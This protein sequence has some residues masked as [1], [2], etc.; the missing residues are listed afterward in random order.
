MPLPRLT[1]SPRVSRVVRPHSVLRVVLKLW[2]FDPDPHPKNDTFQKQ[3]TF[4]KRS[5]KHPHF[6][7]NQMEHDGS[8]GNLWQFMAHPPSAAK[9]SG[10]WSFCDG[11]EAVGHVSW[12]KSSAPE[13]TKVPRELVGSGKHG[14]FVGLF[15]KHES[16]GFR[17]NLY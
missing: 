13:V 11:P 3:D 9:S 17:H 7:N 6:R 14:K 1:W 2:P 12:N 5:T 8:Y 10:G 4:V 15:C 16:W